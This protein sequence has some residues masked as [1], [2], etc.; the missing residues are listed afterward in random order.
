MTAVP[1]RTA[2]SHAFGALAAALVGTAH[3]FEEISLA[4]LDKFTMGV[5]AIEVL[6]GC[7]HVHRQPRGVRQTAGADPQHDQGPAAT[8]MLINF[9]LLGAALLMCVWLVFYPGPL[10]SCSCC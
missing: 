8:R 10:R 5:L 6:L 2:L 1:Q 9:A 7:S 3:Y 4:H